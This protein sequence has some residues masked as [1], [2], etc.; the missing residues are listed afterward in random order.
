MDDKETKKP[1]S[2]DTG[3]GDKSEEVAKAEQEDARVKRMEEATAERNALLDREEARE[4][5]KAVGGETEAG[6]PPIPPKDMTTDEAAIEYSKSIGP[7]GAN[8]LKEDGF[9]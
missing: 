8:P 5:E 9:I 1:V 7:G 4:A 2:K 6:Q 3:K